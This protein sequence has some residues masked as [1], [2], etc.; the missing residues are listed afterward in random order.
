M[1]YWIHGLTGGGDKWRCTHKAGCCEDEYLRP[2]CHMGEPAI[3]TAEVVS[4][5]WQLAVWTFADW[6]TMQSRGHVVFHGGEAHIPCPQCSHL[7][8]LSSGQG[9]IEGFVFCPRVECREQRR[10]IYV[11][12]DIAK[13]PFSDALNAARTACGGAR[14][15]PLL[16]GMLSRLQVPVLHCTGSMAKALTHFTLACLPG[17]V[18]EMAKATVLA[19]T[20]KG[21]MDAIYMREFRELVAHAVARPEIYSRDLDRVFT[22]LLQLVQLMNAAWRASL[23]DAGA[24]ERSGAS[25]ITRLAASIMGPLYQEVKPL[26]PD[27]KEKQVFSLY[28][29]APIAHLRHQV[30]ANRG[31]VAHV[32]DDVMEG[33]IRG[34]GRYSYNHGNNASQAALMSDMADLCEATVKFSTPRSHPSSLVF[35]KH[36][37]V[38]A[39]WKTL[40]ALGTKDYEALAII[41]EQDELLDVERR[42]GGEELYF[43]LP[44]HDVV[45][46]NKAR[47]LDAS[48]RTLT[49]KK[50]TLRRGLGR[51]QTVINAC[52]CGRLPGNGPSAVMYMARARHAAARVSASR[53]TAAAA[54]AGPVGDGPG[55]STGPAAATAGARNAGE[56]LGDETDTSGGRSPGGSGAEDPSPTTDCARKTKRKGTAKRKPALSTVIMGSLPPPWLLRRCFPMPAAYATAMP[57]A[58]GGAED[59]PASTIDAV[60]RKHIAILKLF[61][62]RTKSM[63]FARWSVEASV[64]ADDVVEAAETMLQRLTDVRMGHMECLDTSMF[65]D[66]D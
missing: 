12:H 29:H 48:G 15:Y 55:F 5:Q 28:L 45:H 36:I 51:R 53:A 66:I 49:G 34:V 16:R 64:D 60:L 50:E 11:L 52:F 61:L 62:M 24:S 58:T 54:A 21:S 47:R 35:T 44:L 42:S 65:M 1:L 41:G 31:G 33:H 59:P 38:C 40:G 32:S 8:P 7:L 3:R 22:I 6:C 10:R 2:S 13:S 30:G 56:K 27:T 37:R 43:T 20:G 23:A 14:G 18:Q 57:V 17:T 9:L 19:I 25:S 26:D 63:Q 39:C 4:E 46:A